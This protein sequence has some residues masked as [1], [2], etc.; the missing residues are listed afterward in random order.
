MI[1]D[2]RYL[3][4][5]APAIILGMLAQL[6]LRSAYAKAMKQAAP[7]SGAAAAR[8]ILDAAGLQNVAIERVAGHLSDHYDPRAKVLRLSPEVY[9]ERTAASVGI[10]A[11]E[12]GHAIQDAR[13]YAPLIIRNMAVPA[14][15]FGGNFSFILLF[16]GLLIS[17]SIPALGQGMIWGGI[18][19]F[20]CVVFFQLINL[21]VEFDAS[22]RARG[23]LID[24]NIVP[25]DEMPAVRGV[26]NAAALTYVAGTLQSVMTLMYYLMLASARRD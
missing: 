2:F 24:M 18:A 10:A 19:L 8:H 26:L 23:I 25:R 21:P 11:H 1:F 17:S 16:I 3:L 9:G 13:N 15:Q 5:I 20:S 12:A 22:S 4:F 14:A 6:W 7:L